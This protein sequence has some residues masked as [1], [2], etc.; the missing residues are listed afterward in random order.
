MSSPYEK[1][2]YLEAYARHTDVRV[3]EDPHEAIGGLW[4][5]L[6]RLQFDFLVRHGL[7]RDHALLDLGCGTLR[8]GRHFIRYLNPGRYTG[9]DMSRGAIDYAHKLVDDEGLR[10]KN[11]A[12]IVSTEKN[13]QFERFLGQRFDFLLAQSVFTHLMAEHIEECFAHIGKIM[14][15]QSLFFFTYFKGNARRVADKSFSYPLAFFTDLAAQNGMTIERCNDYD[16]PRQQRM[17][18]ARLADPAA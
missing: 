16:H 14:H 18:V 10:D 12:L 11:P 8:G 7:Q 5:E 17:L 1:L 3:A 2:P 9:F 15:P 4:E 6:G 13:L